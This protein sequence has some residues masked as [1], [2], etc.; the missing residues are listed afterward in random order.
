MRVRDVVHSC[1]HDH[2]A[3]AAVGSIGGRF[4]IDVRSSAAAQGLSVGQFASQRVRQFT[5][6]ASERDWRIVQSRMQGADLA[7]LA[8][9]E[10]L[11]GQ[12]MSRDGQRSPGR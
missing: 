5:L 3:E 1:S 2:V 6:Q 8:G 7:L 11:M 10:A 4:A 12:M 9:L